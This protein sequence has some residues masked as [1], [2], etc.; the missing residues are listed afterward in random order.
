[1]CVCA[2][3]VALNFALPWTVAQ[4]IFRKNTGEGKPF[5]TKGD[6]PNLGIKSSL[7]IVALA[8]GI[9]TTSTTWEAK[10]KEKS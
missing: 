6:L 1:M 9:F 4:G 8:G 7:E 10:V 3:I 2:T 5:P